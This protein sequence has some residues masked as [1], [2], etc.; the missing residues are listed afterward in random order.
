MSQDQAGPET[1]AAPAER[2]LK[3]L[4]KTEAL[5]EPAALRA[6]ED[7]E[8]VHKLRV[9]T[10]RAQAALDV[11]SEAIDE[12]SRKTLRKAL[13]SIRRAASPARDADVHLLALE[14]LPEAS[15]ADE[16]EGVRHAIER[17]REE[18]ESAQAALVELVETGAARKLAKRRERLDAGALAPEIARRAGASALNRAAR[19][20]EE[21]A[22]AD[23]TEIERLHDVRKRAKHLRYTLELLEGLVDDGA[24]ERT[25]GELRLLQDSLGALNDQA[26]ILDRLERYHRELERG[27]ERNERAERGLGALVERFRRELETLASSAREA[28]SG[29][30]A[31][32]VIVDALRL[33]G[34]KANGEIPA[35]TGEPGPR[36]L[37][38]ATEALRVNPAANRD[39]LAAIDVGTNSIRLIIAELQEDGGYRVIDDEKEITR[40]GAGLAETGRMTRASIDRSVAT[41]K[42]MRDIAAGYGA[43]TLRAVGTAVARDA[44]NA[45]E[46][47]RAMLDGAGVDLEIISPEREAQLAFR[48]VAASFD[49]RDLAVAIV[50]IGG[51]STEVV[52]SSRGLIETVYAIPLGAVRLTERFGGPDEAC[53]SRY[54]EMRDFVRKQIKEIVGKPPF[55]PQVMI[56]TG[57]TLTTLA[58][59]NLHQSRGPLW[60]QDDSAMIRGHEMQRSD[61]RHMLDRLRKMTL[62][63]RSRVPG[64]PTERADIIVPGILLGEVLMKRL[65]VNEARVHD[66]GIRD[67]LLLEMAERA[68]GGS[69]ARVE[70]GSGAD[71]MKSVH[72]FASACKYDHA[73]C[74]HTAGLA[75]QVF[76]QLRELAGR[77][78]EAP[79]W[80]APLTDEARTILEAASLLQDVGYHINYTRHHKHSHHL[81]LHAD[82]PGF[83]PR[84]TRVIANVARYHRRAAPKM[85]HESYARLSADDR[86]MVRALSA[87]LRIAGGLDRAHVQRVSGVRL[88]MDDQT[89]RFGVESPEDPHVELWGA[90]R[91]SELFESVFHR[92]ATFEW[93][94]PFDRESDGT[95]R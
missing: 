55:T 52:L 83:S 86:A 72:R 27:I 30:E 20:L 56:G 44:E 61:L 81:I 66:R 68:R 80:A 11:F 93:A 37:D 21:A 42:R 2:L 31:H 62:A 73:H 26:S 1:A 67:G 59:M 17:T 79:A 18:R 6:E 76:D 75:L 22:S 94:P 84:Q 60:A 28:W 14:A 35:E 24:R 82:L 38:P 51:G 49:I 95:S 71:A 85:K 91:K 78:A 48:S 25:L 87:I 58:A 53:G 63:E 69:A 65:G 3:R 7:I 19:D 5:I 70:G 45:E 47:R 89:A 34:E 74:E 33:A 23:L 40:L 12:R 57:G 41:V 88:A 29:E 77:E 9:A 92:R 36:A 64:L 54:G 4:R 90:S 46:L 39:R 32:E 10:R 15:S 16:R 13:K 8:H 50:D 43:A